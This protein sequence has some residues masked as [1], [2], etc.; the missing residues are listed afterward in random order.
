MTRPATTC[1]AIVAALHENGPLTN[2]ALLR[3][4]PQL[5]KQVLHDGLSNLR[6]RGMVETLRYGR[7]A[8]HRLKDGPGRVITHRMGG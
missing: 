7:R 6:M 3:E 5:T 2:V 1:N 4:C 8:V